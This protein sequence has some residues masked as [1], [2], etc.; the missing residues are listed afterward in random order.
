MLLVRVNANLRQ[1]HQGPRAGG[2]FWALDKANDLPRI[3]EKMEIK[4]ALKTGELYIQ[5]ADQNDGW[6]KVES[7]SDMPEFKE[8]W[9]DDY[10]ACIT[11]KSITPYMPEFYHIMREAV[12]PK[13]GGQYG[14]FETIGICYDCD[15][16]NWKEQ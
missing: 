13:C 8:V 3:D 15:Y 10:D 1:L 9:M 16:T 4:F 7:E 6:E 5:N 12:C 11:Y 14:D 2:R